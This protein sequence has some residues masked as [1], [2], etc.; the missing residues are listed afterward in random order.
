MSSA[1][2]GP[3]P[4]PAPAPGTDGAPGQTG[5]ASRFPGTDNFFDSIR[6]MGIS[7]SEDRWI[8]GVATG[9]AERFGIDPLIV[10]GILFVT[11]FIS[12]AG[13]V[14]YGIGWA[15]LPERKDGRIHLQEAFR[16]H[17]DVAM[18]GAVAMAVV[19]LSW[20]DSWVSWW[21]FMHLG[22][23][24]GLFW[25]AAAAAI[26][27][28]VVSLASQRKQTA[29]QA[30]GTPPGPGPIPF[31]APSATEPSSAAFSATA[32]PAATPGATASY[33]V[34]PAS[35][36]GPTPHANPAYAPAPAYGVPPTPAGRTPH[37]HS[38]PPRGTVPPSP[39]APEPPRPPKPPRT[40]GPGSVMVGIVVGLT[41]VSGAVLLFAERND[42]DWFPFLLT[43][44]GVGVVLAGLGIV[45]SGLRGRRS[46]VLGF[47]AIVGLLLSMPLA[48]GNETDG[49]AIGD[50]DRFISEG[51]RVITDRETAEDGFRVA[52]GDPTL[53]LTDL[54]L[55]GVTGEDPVVVPVR[56]AAGTLDIVVP[57]DVAVQADVR[58]GAGQ[59]TWS[60]DGTEEVVTI[61]NSR[62]RRTTFTNEEVRDGQDPLILLDIN[63]GAGTLTIT[64]D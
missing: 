36:H 54:D 55:R 39:V 27:V 33:P 49:F 10:R 5:P 28:M 47:F 22:W 31:D 38:P 3:G 8:G 57:D 25:L 40:K 18:L 29:R 56:L 48:V 51:T 42:S 12:G 43:W 14:L 46:G 9:I 15:L 30:P 34:T 23:L 21:D 45:I 35:G 59:A 32:P 64:E 11:F 19:G 62:N 16:G 20:G 17:F 13:L 37:R 53:D 44:V 6:R 26:V 1:D 41:L 63:V 61:D 7:R 50:R 58:V 60:V 24:N 2:P 4:R 52:F